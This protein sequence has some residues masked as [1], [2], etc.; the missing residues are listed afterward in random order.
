MAGSAELH[1]FG[2]MA[3]TYVRRTLHV[4]DGARNPEHPTIG[5][6]RQTEPRNTLFQQGQR[7]AVEAAETLL[8][9][10]SH[11]AVAMHTFDTCKT[12]P[13]HAAGGVDPALDLRR[14][15]SR[16]DL[17]H[18][19]KIQR[20]YLETHIDAVEERPGDLPGVASPLGLVAVTP[21]AA[22]AVEPAR[23]WVHGGDERK[24]GGEGQR[25]IGPGDGHLAVL[26]GLSQDLENMFSELGQFVEK[27]DAIVGQGYLP[28][29]W[30]DAAA[31][32]AGVGNGMMRG[33]EW[34]AGNNAPFLSGFA[35][36]AIDARRFE[37]LFVAHLRQ[38][39]GNHSDIMKEVFQP[40]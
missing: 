29:L 26:E 8:Q 15:L 14:A 7:G 35:G 22:V 5:P 1:R 39:G 28:R 38:D 32:Q 19:G 12:L 20:R 6:S 18:L 24:T 34:P 17:A 2:N 4:S 10:A 9:P 40:L 11:M 25:H 23:T 27:K 33:A 37:N 30:Q 31:D 21:V 36:D 13:L 3:N 16:G